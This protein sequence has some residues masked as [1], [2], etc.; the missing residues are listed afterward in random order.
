MNKN[1][2]SRPGVAQTFTPHTQEAGRPL[3]VQSQPGLYSRF[4]VNQSYIERSGQHKQKLQSKVCGAR[5]TEGMLA[6]G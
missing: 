5:V 6:F 2:Q 4:Q 3:Q 1:L